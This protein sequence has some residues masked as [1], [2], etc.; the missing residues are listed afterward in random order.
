VKQIIKRGAKL[1]LKR[2]K[3]LKKSSKSSVER[4]LA[5]TKNNELPTGGIRTY[6]DHPKAYPEVTGYFIPTLI[7]YGCSG[8]ALRSLEWLSKIQQKD[9]SFFSSDK[10]K[11][12]SFDTAQ[13]LRGFLAGY[14]KYGLYKE[15]I[16]LATN[17]L[18]SQFVDNGKKG[19]VESYQNEL[20]P[21]SIN[22]F[23][24]PPLQEALELLEKK[25]SLE[26]IDN[27]IKYYA[28][29]DDFLKLE[30]LNH[31]LA[32][33]I[34]GLID[35]GKTEYVNSILAKLS[36]IQHKDGSLP[37]KQGV[38][39]VC[40]TGLAQIAICWYKTGYKSSADRAVEWLEEN[41][42]KSGGFFGSTKKIGGYF[43]HH[44]I[45]WATKFYLDTYKLKIKHYFNETHELYPDNIDR[46]DFEFRCIMSHIKQNQKI[47]DIGCGKGRFL[48]LIK[49]LEPNVDCTGIDISPKLL[50]FAPDSIKKIAGSLENIPLKNNLFDLVFAVESIEHSLNKSGAI[51]EMLRIL[52]PGGL[53][54]IIDKQEAEWG[55]LE[56][57]QW[58][59][60]PNKK[61]LVNLLR[62]HCADVIATNLRDD[63]LFICWQGRKNER[64]STIF[65]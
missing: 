37:A 63:Q 45:S 25:E 43:P 44:E 2:L 5:W 41:Q 56:T 60:W 51:K 10:K 52:K 36:E 59:R 61:I 58:E 15:N 7:E 20:P 30:T 3:N 29:Q 64:S 8:I 16:E 14:K 18:L 1:F 24:L 32:Y 28:N 26:M 55:R 35:L 57:E 42:N 12:Y 62:Q 31:F 21:E 34:D 23:S 19:F 17:Y 47:A 49:E 22:L 46:D 65:N 11:S 13:V 39:W 48:R 33:E 54:I 9:G 50:S 27:S 4:A 53:L 40:T 38:D 6:T